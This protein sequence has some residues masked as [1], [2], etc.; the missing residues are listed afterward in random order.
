MRTREAIEHAPQNIGAS[1]RSRVAEAVMIVLALIAGVLIV[2]LAIAGAAEAADYW[3]L[4]E[5]SGRVLITNQKP[6]AGATVVQHYDLPEATEAEIA[7]ARAQEAAWWERYQ[8]EE[9]TRAVQRLTEEIIK[10][11]LAADRRQEGVGNQGVTVNMGSSTAITVGGG[12]G[13]AKK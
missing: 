6:K 1:V 7:T 11:R 12:R 8:Q 9:R 4:R 2:M 5:S 10:Q 3:I 13:G